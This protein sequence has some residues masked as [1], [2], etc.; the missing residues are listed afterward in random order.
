MAAPRSPMPRPRDFN[1]YR[2]FWDKVSIPESREGCWVWTGTKSENHYGWFQGAGAHRA[3]W[4]IANGGIPFGRFVC[5]KCDNKLCVN[6][7]HLFLGTPKDNTQDMMRKGRQNNNPLLGERAANAKLSSD[8]VKEIRNLYGN[9][10]IYQKTIAVMFGITQGYVTK[11]VSGDAWRHL[12]TGHITNK[13]FKSC[14][15]G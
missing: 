5:H 13:N 14:L 4:E 10:G 9:G 11:I 12:D 15:S 1:Y 2:A 7:A 3:S 8:Q 6:P